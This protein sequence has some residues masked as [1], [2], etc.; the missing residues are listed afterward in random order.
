[1]KVGYCVELGFPQATLQSYRG[2]NSEHSFW[3]LADPPPGMAPC[4]DL[5]FLLLG[6]E[7]VVGGWVQKIAGG[8]RRLGAGDFHRMTWGDP[9]TLL[10]EGFCCRSANGHPD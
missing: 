2:F 5:S 1:M 4:V 10:T 3:E 6:L 7:K 8:V 9:W